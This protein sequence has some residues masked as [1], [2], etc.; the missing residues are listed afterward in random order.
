M[1][2]VDTEKFK[3][4]TTTR[5]ETRRRFGIKKHHYAILFVGRLEQPK[6]PGRLLECIPFLNAQGLNFQ[7]FFA[8]DGT[9]RTYLENYVMRNRFETQ[10][11]FLGHVS[12]VE[13]PFFY[14][15]ADM[16]ALPSQMEGVPMVI[17]EALACGTPVV[18]SNVGGI[19]DLI[20]DNANGIVLDDLSP[21][22][23]A[24]AIIDVFHFNIPRRQI[25]QSVAELSAKR[26]VSDLK[27]IVYNLLVI[28]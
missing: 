13:L 15:M 22:R 16:L 6:G 14:N 17:L 2:A 18:A 20:V 1:N 21:E 8:G 4:N 5:I 7:I 3:P 27:K 12:H 28:R 24:S 19:S 10:V 26:F 11:T 9:Y 25:S 23:L